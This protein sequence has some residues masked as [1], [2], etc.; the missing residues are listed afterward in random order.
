MLL[1]RKEGSSLNNNPEIK[2]GK[3]QYGI[4]MDYVHAKAKEKADYE[5]DLKFAERGRFGQ[6][7]QNMWHRIYWQQVK[8]MSEPVYK[9][10]L[11]D[12]Q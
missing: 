6:D 7:A 4:D 12:H 8:A 10:P 5:I 1:D 3:N 11:V 9:S 2:H